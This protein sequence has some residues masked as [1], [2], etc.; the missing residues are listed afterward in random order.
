MSKQKQDLGKGIQ[1][2]LENMDQEAGADFV[3][4]KKGG[5]VAFQY[6]STGGY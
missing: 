6:H 1:A 4:K 3:Q 2:L 5:D